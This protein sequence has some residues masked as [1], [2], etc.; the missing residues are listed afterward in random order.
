V[1]G[2]VWRQA[3]GEPGGR[4]TVAFARPALASRRAPGERRRGD[5]QSRSGQAPSDTTVKLASFCVA[6]ATS[7]APAAIAPVRAGPGATHGFHDRD[8]E[9]S[10]KFGRREKPRCRAF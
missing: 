9:R 2:R 6:N 1:T 8:D 10:T 5:H 4:W 3:P 7:E